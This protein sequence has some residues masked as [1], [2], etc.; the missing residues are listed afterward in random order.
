MWS[1][2]LAPYARVA[3]SRNLVQYSTA[4]DVY[5]LRV[6]GYPGSEFD[7]PAAGAEG[8][9][10]RRRRRNN[11][12][13]N[14]NERPRKNDRDR[15]FKGVVVKDRELGKRISFV[16]YLDSEITETNLFVF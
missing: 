12:S 15:I 3:I 9:L 2:V 1:R 10:R 5:S 13:L 16:T 11:Q 6:S 7:F 4:V 14:V 8:P